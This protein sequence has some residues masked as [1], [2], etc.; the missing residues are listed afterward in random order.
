[1]KELTNKEIHLE[2]FKRQQELLEIPYGN[3]IE[4]NLN[5]FKDGAKWARDILESQKI[6]WMK[7]A[8]EAGQENSYSEGTQYIVYFEEWYNQKN[9]DNER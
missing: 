8:F 5:D 1:M 9:Q 7:E 6:E 4:Y 2:A 3:I